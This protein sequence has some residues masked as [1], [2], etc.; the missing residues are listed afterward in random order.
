M[1]YGY[2]GTVWLLTELTAPADAKPGDV[3]T[4]KA[5]GAWLVCKEVCIP[6][7]GDLSLPLTVSANPS[8]PYATVADKFA[9]ARAKLPA[10]SPW[11]V[12]FSAGTDLDLFVAAPSLVRCASEGCDVLPP[13]S[14][15]D[16]RFRAPAH[17]LCR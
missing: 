14:G 7:E 5:H 11:P 13:A 4:L 10:P 9:A 2:A 1:D 12:H 6:E 3:V 16:R 15:R 8:P 17:G